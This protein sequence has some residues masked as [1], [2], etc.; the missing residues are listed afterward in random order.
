[1]AQTG[2][3]LTIPLPLTLESRPR[4]LF[5]E[6]EMAEA[7]LQAIYLVGTIFIFGLLSGEQQLGVLASAMIGW[8][9]L[10]MFAL[11]PRRQDRS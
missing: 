6:W 10:F 11:W 9:G 3:V 7:A 8:S 1:M 2:T 5:R 4:D